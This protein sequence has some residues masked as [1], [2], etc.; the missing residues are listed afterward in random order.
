MEKL[1][2]YSKKPKIKCSIKNNAE[3][4]VVE[5]ISFEGEVLEAG[6]KLERKGEGDYTHFI[7]EKK[8]W[9]TQKAVNEI[10]KRLGIGKKRVS[11]AGTKDRNALTVQLCSVFR[12]EPE[13]LLSL[14]IKDI[15]INGAWK[16]DKELKLG[17]LA[18]NRFKIKI[19][20]TDAEDVEEKI[21]DISN[22]LE[23][24]FPNYFGEQRFGSS[25][26]NTHEVGKFIIKGDAENAVMNYLTETEGEKNKEAVEAR[27]ELSETQDFKKAFHFF[28]KHL[29]LEKI[30]LSH[31]SKSPNDFANALRKLPRKTLL[32]F[33]HA[34]QSYLF[35]LAVSER[36]KEGKIKKEKGERFCGTNRY[37]FPDLENEGNEWLC[38]KIIGYESILNER[39]K[40]LLSSEG[41]RE[42]Q[43][44][45]RI[46]PEIGSKGS[47]RTFFSPL[48]DFEFSANE[49]KFSLPPGSYATSALREFAE[50]ENG[51]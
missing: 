25:R 12:V 7:L 43:F 11:Y 27:K 20:D 37:G 38:I 14:N 35:N 49:F 45:V 42:E 31:L 46:I 36:I 1:S 6:G 50:Y 19:R 13:K 24:E 41:I 10:S 8:N 48:K 9:T 22:E 23:R 44:K 26:K 47:M 39:E 4:F 18:G 28:P 21:T 5:E 33:V 29:T 51:I 2:F 15:Q 30:M 16:S 34:F 17:D 40:K 3:D 32:M